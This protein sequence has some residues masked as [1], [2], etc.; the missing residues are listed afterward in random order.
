MARL[1]REGKTVSG[2]LGSIVRTEL[3]SEIAEDIEACCPS[4]GICYYRL[5]TPTRLHSPLEALLLT[6]NDQIREIWA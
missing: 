3:W 1:L 4:S 2:S 5:N 6:G